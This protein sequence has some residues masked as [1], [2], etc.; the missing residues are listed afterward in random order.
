M[1]IIQFRIKW[2]ISVFCT[3]KSFK[4]KIFSFLKTHTLNIFSEIIT[5]HEIVSTFRKVF[6]CTEVFENAIDVL[7][8]ESY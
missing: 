8:K 3:D 1:N 2:Q 6:L 4:S 7:G 5:F